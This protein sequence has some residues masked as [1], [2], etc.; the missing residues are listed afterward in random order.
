MGREKW[1]TKSEGTKS[2]VKMWQREKWA[3]KV[4]HKVGREKWGK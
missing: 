3:T 1:G 2:G 4:G